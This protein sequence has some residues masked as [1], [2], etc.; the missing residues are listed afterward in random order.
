MLLDPWRRRFGSSSSGIGR[1]SRVFGPLKYRPYWL[2]GPTSPLAVSSALWFSLNGLGQS[3]LSDQSNPLCE[4]HLPLESCP[5]KP[6]RPAAA[7]QPLSWTFLPYSTSGTEDPLH[8]GI[9]ARYVP[10]SGFGYPLD[11]FLPSDPCR[12][13]FTPAALLG[14]A[15]RS[16]LLPKGNRRFTSGWTR[17]PFLLSVLPPPKRWAGPTG[18]G[19]RALTL[20]RVPG[21]RLVISKPSRWMLP[22]D[23]PF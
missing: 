15:L 1:S 18:R 7:N 19:F 8:A 22:W 11:G 21:G 14:F 9:P 2:G 17:L 10:P 13:S 3:Q 4:F 23:L 20:P 16:F 6:S 12:F 5:A